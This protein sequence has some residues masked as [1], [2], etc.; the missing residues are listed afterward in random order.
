M[1]MPL[2]SSIEAIQVIHRLHFSNQ[3]D[4]SDVTPSG[5][6]PSTGGGRM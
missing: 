4:S 3:L 2:T 6:L 5:I 1:S